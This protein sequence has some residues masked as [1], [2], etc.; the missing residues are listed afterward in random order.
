MASDQQL[1]FGHYDFQ[2]EL[3]GHLARHGL[4]VRCG[5]RVRADGDCGYDSVLANLEDG[6][7]RQGISQRAKDADLFSV[8]EMRESVAH[9]MG[10]NKELQKLS[11][12]K[13]LQI[14]TKNDP[15]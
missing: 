7:I 3:N 12:F 4:P 9:F 13:L 15:V 14:A 1:G 2:A 5:R 10:T 6:A 8:K 11:G